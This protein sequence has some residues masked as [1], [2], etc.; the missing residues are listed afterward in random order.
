MRDGVEPDSASEKGPHHLFILEARLGALANWIIGRPGFA[1]SGAESLL[2]LQRALLGRCLRLEEAER[3]LA[4]QVRG[5]RGG[6]T[7]RQVELE[8]L[9]LSRDLHTGVGQL[10]AAIRLQVE[11]IETGPWLPPAREALARISRLAQDAME[12]VRALSL[13]MHPPEWQRLT[14]EAA[15]RQLWELSGIPQ[16]FE[17][18]LR[19]EPFPRQPSLELKILTYRAAQEAVSNIARHARATR[20]EASLETRGNHLALTIR[21][22]GAGFDSAGL[23]SAPA[24]LAAGIGL[25]S[26]R[27]Q[28]AALGGKLHVESGPKGTTL[29]LLAPFSPNPPGNSRLKE[30][31]AGIAANDRS[32]RG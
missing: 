2:A 30:K 25:R 23:L 12:Q 26:I 24:S 20:V 6:G 4:G 14:L 18:S 19:I 29:E 21:D 31:H 9:R 27:E 11:M 28:A 17:G 7:I 5:R 1:L 16:R 32:S 10:L 22:N 13:R 15:L 3:G 8:R